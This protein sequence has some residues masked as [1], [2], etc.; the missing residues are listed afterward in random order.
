MHGS[1]HSDMMT[2]SDLSLSDTTD[3]G[4]VMTDV[5]TMIN[6]PEI[7][8]SSVDTT[9]LEAQPPAAESSVA[10]SSSIDSP[11]KKILEQKARSMSKMMEKMGDGNISASELFQMHQ[12]AD[13]Q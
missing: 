9:A 13:A 10:Q 5:D 1:V 4:D 3:V 11:M 7:S 6:Q 12:A 8:E 2:N